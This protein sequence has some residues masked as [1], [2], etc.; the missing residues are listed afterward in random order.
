MM[1]LRD[2]LGAP[3]RFD[4]KRAGQ[5]DSLGLRRRQ[6]RN[7]RET[8]GK[9]SRGCDPDVDIGTTLNGGPR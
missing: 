6:G 2:R 9:G 3:R 4:A 1:F 7:E 5:S 8:N